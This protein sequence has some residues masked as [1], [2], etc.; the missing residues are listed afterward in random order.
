MADLVD[1]LAHGLLRWKSL[2]FGLLQEGELAHDLLWQSRDAISEVRYGREEAM[3]DLF[4]RLLLLRWAP[5]WEWFGIIVGWTCGGCSS[6]ARRLPSVGDAHLGQ[7][8]IG[9][10]VSRTLL[11]R[12]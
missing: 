4:L 12:V 1:D 2:A 7:V 9:A 10:S 6:R 3:L 11:A 8:C 5:V